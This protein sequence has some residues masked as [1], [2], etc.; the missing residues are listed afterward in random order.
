MRGHVH[1]RTHTHARTLRQ[2]GP[3]DACRSISAKSLLT[4]CTSTAGGGA[5]GWEPRG[6]REE[7]AV[8]KKIALRAVGSLRRYTQLNGL[9]IAF[10][11][12]RQHT[13]MRIPERTRANMAAAVRARA[14]AHGMELAT[15]P[16]LTING[17]CPRGLD[18]RIPPSP[19]THRLSS[20]TLR[21]LRHPTLQSGTAVPYVTLCGLNRRFFYFTGPTK[22]RR[23]RRV[24]QGWYA[25]GKR[26]PWL[27]ETAEPRSR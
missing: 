25:P 16:C 18:S 11:Y 15:P 23:R 1:A 4:R 17:A 20:P 12:G 21:Q 2:R 5:Q 24:I 26:A 7:E 22:R 3:S 10:G 8:E 9:A 6:G 19:S 13:R 14:R 27:V